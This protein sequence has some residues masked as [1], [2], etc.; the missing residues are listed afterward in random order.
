M[1]VLIFVVLGSC[2]M[3]HTRKRPVTSQSAL[4]VSDPRSSSALGKSTKRSLIEFVGAQD[5]VDGV[6][7][8]RSESGSNYPSQLTDTQLYEF[9]SDVIAR[10]SSISTESVFS[11]SDFSSLETTDMGYCSMPPL[12]SN[13]TSVTSPKTANVSST[14]INPVW[15]ETG[16]NERSSPLSTHMIFPKRIDV[17]S[18]R[19]TSSSLKTDNI[20]STLINYLWS[21]YEETELNRYSSFETTMSPLSLNRIDRSSPNITRSLTSY[22]WFSP[23]ES[24]LT[25]SSSSLGSVMDSIDKISSSIETLAFSSAQNT[26]DEM[27]PEI[28]K[29]ASECRKRQSILPLLKQELKTKI[30][31]NRLRAGKKELQVDF[32]PSKSKMTFEEL[33]KRERRREQNRMSALRSRIRQKQNEED[34]EKRYEEIEREHTSLLHER[35]SLE[36]EKTFLRTQLVNHLC[37]GCQLDRRD[38][39]LRTMKSSRVAHSTTV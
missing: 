27:T 8:S 5:E 23:D 20:P 11:E 7:C 14:S 15:P 36:E 25:S 10:S 4:G 24:E 16:E 22:S 32:T 9:D 35:N 26:D 6:G 34:V 38:D 37:H 31:L 30:Q 12:S 33:T 28:N 13:V 2:A 21:G 17:S 1:E 29:A 18:D 39:D 3:I 19:K